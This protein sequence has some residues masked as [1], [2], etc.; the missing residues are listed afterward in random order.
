MKRVKFNVV[1]YFPKVTEI[2]YSELVTEPGLVLSM[3][4]IYNRY[5]AMGID[6][7]K[8][9]LIDDDEDPD[10]TDMYD[11]EVDD[12]LDVMHEAQQQ[13]ERGY[14]RVSKKRSARPQDEAPDKE[15]DPDQKPEKSEQSGDD[16]GE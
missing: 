9:D 5:V 3:R 16:K 12:K 4:E 13:A 11:P 7:L 6:P 15:P 8:G 2:D 14:A 10:S 1:D